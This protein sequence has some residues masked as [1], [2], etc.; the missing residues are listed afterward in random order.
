[1]TTRIVIADDQELIR[2]GFRLVLDAQPDMTVVGEAADGVAALEAARL[3]QPD[4]LL[5][6]IRMPRLDGLEVVRRLAGPGAEPGP[7]VVVVTTFDHDEYVQLALRDGAAGYLL[8]RAGPTLLVEAVRA[9]MSGEALLSPSITVRLL[10]D[11]NARTT[12]G[13]RTDE[14][15]DR[16]AER[17]TEREK[18]VVR[19]V[20]AGLTNA[21]IGAE[22]FISPGTV[23][24][25]LASA[26]RRLAVR[27]RVGLAAWAWRAGLAEA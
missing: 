14:R 24:T 11:L 3:L 6:D 2:H 21:E 12:D 9:A 25:H 5:A 19:L 20:A 15:T 17:L 16:L 18:D 13:R 1:M 10:R 8:K 22:L 26:Q 27:N 7:R 23:K 4:V